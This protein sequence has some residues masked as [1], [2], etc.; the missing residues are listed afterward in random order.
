VFVIG[1]FSGKVESGFPCE[2]ATMQELLEWF[3]FPVGVKPSQAFR[4]E[5]FGVGLQV[6]H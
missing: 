4:H 5:V 6:V 1:A 2:N 3:L